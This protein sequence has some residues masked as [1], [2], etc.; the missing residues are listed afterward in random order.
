MQSQPVHK[1]LLCE[2]SLRPGD[3]NSCGQHSSRTPC[4]QMIFIVTA[5]SFLSSQEMVVS[6]G[7]G[8]SHSGHSQPYS[9]FSAAE[10]PGGRIPSSLLD[11]STTAWLS[12][13]RKAL[14]ASHKDGNR[15]AFPIWLLDLYAVANPR[16]H[17]HVHMRA[18]TYWNTT[19]IQRVSLIF[20]AH[21]LQL[22][23]NSVLIGM[24]KQTLQVIY[25]MK[26]SSV[27]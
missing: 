8:A 15:S 7:A 26:K 21:S 17:M 11:F 22:I 12:L 18:R 16:T 27:F 3:R 5:R 6:P 19:R 4:Q 20:V 9:G 2:K 1:C 25:R 24:C 14:F 13:W 10:R 23:Q